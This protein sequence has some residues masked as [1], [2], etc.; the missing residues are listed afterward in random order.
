MHARYQNF[1]IP[2]QYIQCTSVPS[3]FVTCST[4]KSKRVKNHVNVIRKN[5]VNAVQCCSDSL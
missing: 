4:R 2:G 5:V 3:K 1:T